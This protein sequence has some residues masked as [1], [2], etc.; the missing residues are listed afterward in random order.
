L[1]HSLPELPDFYIENKKI[2]QSLIDVLNAEN[3]VWISLDNYLIS[4]W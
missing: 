3:E 4:V 2:L 1:I